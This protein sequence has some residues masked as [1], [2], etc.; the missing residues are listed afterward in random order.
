[1]HILL[2]HQAFATVENAG[3]TRHYELARRLVNDGHEFTIVGGDRSYLTGRRVDGCRGMTCDQRVEGIRVLR[4]YTLPT[5]HRS[6]FWRVVSFLSFTITSVYAALRA[7]KVDLVFGTSPPIFQAVSAWLIAWFRRRPFLLEIRDLWPDF[8]VEMRVLQ[9]RVLIAAARRLELFLYARAT[10][11][12]VNSPAYRDYLMN[13]GVPEA[14][15]SFI[16]NGVDPSMFESSAGR[17][18]IRAEFG[19]ENKFVVVYAGALGMANDIDTIL[20]AADLLRDQRNIHFLVVGDGK[21]RLR[22]RALAE[23]L[24]LPNV[25][26]A[27]ARPK[28]E[29]PDVLSAADACAATLRD[30]PMFRMTYPNKIFDYMAAARP[31]V[32]GIDGVIREVVE[33]AGGGVAIRPGDVRALAE[34]VRALHDNPSAA[35][36]MGQASRKYVVKY[37]H[38]DRHANELSALACRLADRR[39]A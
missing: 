12:I 29:M 34:A 20:R 10:H 38:R 25:T 3:G 31:I 19:L 16:P 27:G 2:I 28:H 17:G 4:A 9:N 39:A 8:A 1:M 33:R 37:F 18:R 30:I 5:Y 7:G 15:V 24:R 11:I 23:S 13:K 21:E 6:F 14:K 32:L 36:R 22:L 26:F 35:R